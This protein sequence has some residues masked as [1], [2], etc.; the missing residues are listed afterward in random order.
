[1]TRLGITV[2]TEDPIQVYRMIESVRLARIPPGD[3][4]E[5]KPEE[6]E[7]VKGAHGR[8]PACDQLPSH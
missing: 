3:H 8:R 4:H 1:M 6:L 5:V 7:R 2:C